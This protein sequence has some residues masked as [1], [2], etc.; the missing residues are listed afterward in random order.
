MRRCKKNIAGNAA[1]DV[2]GSSVQH[3]DETMIWPKRNKEKERFYLLA[4][5][6]GKALRRKHRIFLAWSILLGLMV[7][8]I[9]AVA[10]YFVNT[11][12]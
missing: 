2:A 5:M 1:R 10:L 8:L 9:M 6:G 12:R 11:R 7:S 3:P 4:G